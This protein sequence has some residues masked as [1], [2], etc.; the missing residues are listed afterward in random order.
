MSTSAPPGSSTQLYPS[1]SRLPA[2]RSLSALFIWLHAVGCG[3]GERGEGGRRWQQQQGNEAGGQQVQGRCGEPPHEARVSASI[4]PSSAARRRHPPAKGDDVVLL[5]VGVGGCW[6]RHDRACGR[7]VR[8]E[9][10]VSKACWARAGCTHKANRSGAKRG[11]RLLDARR[12]RCPNCDRQQHHIAWLPAGGAAAAAAAATRR[13][14]ASPSWPQNKASSSPSSMTGGFMS[15]SWSRAVEEARGGAA[16]PV[17]HLVCR[18]RGA[19]TAAGTP[20]PL[21][22]AT[23]AAAAWCSNMRGKS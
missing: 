7:R 9:A 16:R 2:M 12:Q 5:A 22:L 4:V 21:V 1:D 10:C 11:A 3:E 17:G 23:A 18:R 19:Q 15:V 14:S 13:H 20:R 6:A 8:E